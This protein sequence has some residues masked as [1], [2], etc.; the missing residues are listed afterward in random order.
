MFQETTTATSKGNK[1]VN[2]ILNSRNL[3]FYYR[4]LN[5]NRILFGARGDL[6]GSEYSGNKMF[7]KMEKEMKRIFPNWENVEVDYKWRGFV[8]VTTK[9]TP[10][11]GKLDEEEI[12]YSF[13]YHANGVNTAP[14]SGKEL[15]NL[16][17]SNSKELSISKLFLGLPKKF[18]FPSLRL[19]YLK[20]AYYYYSMI[21]R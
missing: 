20:I 18:P 10:S 6:T 9:L 14:W 16:I 17:N 1:T 19:L 7:Q 8:A 3:L 15:A 5:D 13:G 2:P 11:I 4:L 21:D 12:Y